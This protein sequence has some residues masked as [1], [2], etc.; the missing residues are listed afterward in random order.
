MR[1]R[2]FVLLGP[3]GAGKGTQAARLARA[4]GLVHIASG[5]L[6]RNHVARRTELG[7]LAQEYMNRG[8]LVPDEVATS[9]MAQRLA[10]PD[11]VQ[12]AV[13]LDGFP[14]T[15]AQAEALSRLLA[16]QGERVTRA[17]L[18]DVDRG[19]LIR[20][21]TGRWL[22]RVCQ[23]P[24]HETS[25]PPRVPGRCDLCAGEL[26]QRPDDT[27]EVVERRLEVYQRQTKPLLAW[28]ERC[29]ALVRIQGAGDA[30]SVH[31]ALVTALNC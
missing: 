24:Y 22:C 9:M 13:L 3:P 28:Y 10:E 7:K 25:R 20:R 15:V 26:Y 21:L 12:G 2:L 30:E 29:G 27:P 4:M 11:A 31:R 5:D 19:E 6:F 1:R 23:T 14:R 16:A 17:A 8:E 18:I